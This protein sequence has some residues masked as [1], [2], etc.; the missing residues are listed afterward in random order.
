MFNRTP[1]DDVTELLVTV[2]HFLKVFTKCEYLFFFTSGVC[3][4]RNLLFGEKKMK[5]IKYSI[6][7]R[8]DTIYKCTISFPLKYFI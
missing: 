4:F 7:M 3:S 1:V 8:K 6:L 5:Y 2:K